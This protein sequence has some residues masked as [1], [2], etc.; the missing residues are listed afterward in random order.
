MPGHALPLQ[1]LMAIELSSALLFS[2]MLDG[3]ELFMV[4]KLVL[5]LVL[6][7]N[8]YRDARS[9]YCSNNRR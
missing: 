5:Q 1:Q 4:S 6:Y 7:M 9:W 8:Y 2:A 3:D